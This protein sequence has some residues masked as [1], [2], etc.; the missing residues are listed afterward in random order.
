MVRFTD[1]K[2]VFLLSKKEFSRMSYV[3]VC[4]FG[5]CMGCVCGICVC[6]ACMCGVR[7]CSVHGVY[8]YVCVVCICMCV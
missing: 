2:K 5:V 4:V 1:Q 3:C 8:M 7:M 6:C